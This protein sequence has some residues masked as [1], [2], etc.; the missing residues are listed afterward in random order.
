MKFT[1]IISVALVSVM[2]VSMISACNDQNSQETNFSLNTTAQ[3]QLPIQTTVAQGVEGYVFKYR[4]AD[5]RV[6]TDMN[7]ILSTLGDDYAYFEAASCAGLGMSKTYTYGSGSVV[8][9][10]NPNG[11]VDVISSV[12]LYDDTVQTPEGIYIGCTKDQV[13]AAYGQA[14]EE[15]D[16]TLTYELNDTVLVFVFDGN[17]KASNIIYNGIV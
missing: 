15:T 3:S 16:T 2:G 14:S 10:T 7:D 13:V 4:G 9:S 1:K 5:I 12:A 6:N 8:I 11:A 17:G